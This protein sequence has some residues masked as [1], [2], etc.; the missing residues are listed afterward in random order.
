MKISVLSPVYLGEKLTYELV[1][2]VE[3]NVKTI[4]KDYEIILVEDGSPDQSWKIIQEIC[5]INPH[6]KGLKLSRNFG[7]HYAI[8][9]G[10]QEAIGDWII[11]MDCDLQDKPEEIPNL[12]HKAQ[13]GFDIVFAQRKERKDKWLKRLSSKLFYKVFSLLTDTKQDATIANFGIY[14]KKVIQAVLSMKDHIRYFPT[15]V[16]W[17]GFSNTRIQVEHGHRAEDESSYTWGKL[18]RLALDNIIA[19]SDK[20]LRIS[21]NLGLFIS[22]ISMLIGIFYLYKYLK[23][24]I[25]V[26]GFA[27]LIISIW[28]LSGLIIFLLGV[29]GVYLGKTFERVKER[30]HYIIDEKL[31][32]D[33]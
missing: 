11:V 2:R 4:S 26:L 15:M 8:T 33:E 18:I 1:R 31:N 27:S 24:D 22:F 29:L 12:Y 3:K 30:P 10:L 17:V 14:H 7:Q 21:I 20:P 13:E 28:F 16:Q 9:A 23:G 32:F 25:V 19:F 6:V 5:E